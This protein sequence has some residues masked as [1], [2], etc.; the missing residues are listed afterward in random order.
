VRR[1]NVLLRI[2]WICLLFV[3]VGILGFG[4]VTVLVPG[5]G[6]RSLMRA[7][8]VASIGFGLFGILIVVFGFRRRERW[9]WRDRIEDAI[10]R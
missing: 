4:L 5:S 1:E 6:D 2:G 3:G 7:D 9:A 10:G 8:G